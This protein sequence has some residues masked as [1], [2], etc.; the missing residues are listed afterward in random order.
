MREK[1][2]RVMFTYSHLWWEQNW[3][4]AEKRIIDLDGCHVG[5]ICAPHLDQLTLSWHNKRM[6]KWEAIIYTQFIP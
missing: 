3:I 4:H 2:E 5:N 6:N 1:Q